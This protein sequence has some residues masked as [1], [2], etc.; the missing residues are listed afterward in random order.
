MRLPWERTVQRPLIANSERAIPLTTKFPKKSFQDK[1]PYR[2]LSYFS[3]KK[4]D[5]EVFFGRSAL[6]WELIQKVKNNNRLIAVLGASGSGKSSLLRAGLLYHLK[7]GQEI[8]GSNCWTYITPFTP[9]RTPLK[10][11]HEAFSFSFPDLLPNQETMGNF[12]LILASLKALTTP[13]ILIIDQLEECFTMCEKS[14]RKDFFDCLTE[15]IDCTDNLWILIGMRSDFRVRL[16]EYPEFNIKINKPYINVEQLNSE[17]IE[18]AII[19]PAEL[20]GLGIEG[21]LKQQLLN[22]VKDD[23]G[24]LPLL[25]YTLTELWRES[26]NQKDEILRLDT[27]NNL[28]RIAGTLP[29]RADE[30]YNS[31]LAEEQIVARRIFL[32]LTQVGETTNTRR[33]VC[34]NELKNSHHSLEILEK[35]SNTL[36]AQK[37]RLITKDSDKDS[38]D[39]IL[40]VVHEALLRYW[41]QLRKWKEEYQYAIVTERKIEVSAKEWKQGKRILKCS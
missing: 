37:A 5:A 28:G 31:L 1:C 35:V 2:S 26:R 39:V 15:L 18:E 9:R 17:E 3:E 38:D 27:Y 33:R 6:T 40:D 4:E 10:S 25:Q 8:P 23:P 24:S 34:L 22:D 14:K 12:H 20:V 16:R 19:K 32:E 7:L 29:N 41:T 36:A 13:I 30:I 21:P 11:L